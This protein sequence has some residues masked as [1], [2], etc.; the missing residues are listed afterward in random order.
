MDEVGL[1]A[2]AGGAE[3]AD[4]VWFVL[5]LEPVPGRLE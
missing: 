4:M 1:S 3:R 2:P 5:A